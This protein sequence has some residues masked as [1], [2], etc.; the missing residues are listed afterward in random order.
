MYTST[1]FLLGCVASAFAGPACAS[2]IFKQPKAKSFLTID[3]VVGLPVNVSTHDGITAMVPIVS[4]DLKGQFNGHLV[5][6]LTSETERIL[7]GSNGANS[8]SADGLARYPNFDP[9]NI[10]QNVRTELMFEND[11]EERILAKMQGTTTYA[12]NAL[13]GFGYA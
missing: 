5:P 2:G 11:R 7:P 10:S 3:M 8:V 13:H 12:N 1:I 4:G 6:N 9:S